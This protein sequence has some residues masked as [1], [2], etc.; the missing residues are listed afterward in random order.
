ML[1]DEA[2]A[3]DPMP[4][5]PWANGTFIWRLCLADRVDALEEAQRTIAAVANRL[6]HAVEQIVFLSG[7]LGADEGRLP[8]DGVWPHWQRLT[9]RI[10]G[11]WTEL[12][13]FMVAMRDQHRA[14]ISFHVNCTDVNAGLRLYPETREFFARLR[15]A[16]AI[17]ARPQGVNAQPW[18]GLPYVPEAIPE[19][20]ASD[21]FAMVNYQRFW[22]SGLAREQIDGLF[23]CLPYLPPL[24]YVD[25]LGPLG[26]CIH[27]GYPD[28]ELGGSQA[29]QRAGIQSIVR[30]IRACGS[31]VA[32]ES[33]ARL[34]EHGDPPIR[35]SWGHG[36]LSRNDYGLIGSGYGM[37][38]CS[39]R[40]GKAMQV[41]GNQGSYHLQCGDRAPALVVQGWESMAAT[42]DANEHDSADLLRSP[43]VDGLRE[44]GNV[45][46]LV[47]G[48]HFTVAPELYH[49]GCRS[50][51]LPG[52]SNWERLDAAEGRVRLDALTLRAP[53]GS[54]Q[55][56]EAE[57]AVVLGSARIFDDAWASGG[58]TVGRIDE[59]LGNGVE[60]AF[61]VPAAGSYTGFIRY[62]SVGGGIL[63]LCLDDE[64]V[65]RI[66]LPDTGAWQHH[67]DH[68]VTLLLS[69]GQHR[70]RLQCERIY[71]A[72]S[73][74]A[75]A[76]WTLAG[77]FRAWCGEVILG[78]AGD[79]FCPDTW[80]GQ[81]RVLLYSE[82][83][84]ERVWT[85]PQAW[86]GVRQ[87][88]LIP[89]IDSGR[90]PA[91]ARRVPV[92]G[93]HCRLTLKANQAAVLT[94]VSD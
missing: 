88:R 63:G 48:F 53:N 6:D 92:N 26:W 9:Y 47:R 12:A 94:P 82:H 24:L 84:G 45:D 5:P 1:E 31:E 93:L 61:D 8:W 7:A 37:G 52:G 68:P 28:G 58:K 73:D 42:K 21:I 13:R 38:A 60:F 56:H 41:Y 72:W 75:R 19:G 65:R 32:G 4:A 30:Y 87:A 79:R 71:A 74:G 66:E 77:G 11:G 40:G 14:H 15:D 67:G 39:R 36:G 76:E 64:P 23:G 83:G 20:D 34:T 46:D 70:L 59:A 49:I 2:T 91:Q 90:D 3:H 17:F 89:L 25:V 33:P 51:R 86:A 78:I 85:L 22:E 18:F 43:A 80:S 35:Y 29:T 81:Q 55:V 54:L 44:W 10:G 16:R 57:A 50:A 62:A 69:A 27:P